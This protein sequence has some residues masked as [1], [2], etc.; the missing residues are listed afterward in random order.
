MLQSRYPVVVNTPIGTPDI[1][2]KIRAYI[3]DVPSAGFLGCQLYQYQNKS[4]SL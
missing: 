2:A 4:K 3:S 1:Q